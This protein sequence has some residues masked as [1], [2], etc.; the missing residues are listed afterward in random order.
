MGTAAPQQ[1]THL[2]VGLQPLCELD[3]ALDHQVVELVQ[4][5]G[6]YLRRRFAQ[7]LQQR[8]KGVGAVAAVGR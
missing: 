6:I 5:A 7:Q 1:R 2:G 3:Q 8:R 4:S